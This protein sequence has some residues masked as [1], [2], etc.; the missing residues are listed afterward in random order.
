VF[1]TV[2]EWRQADDAELAASRV[3]KGAVTMNGSP[4]TFRGTGSSTA[5][6]LVAP[7]DSAS[8]DLFVMVL[9][10]ITGAGT[11]QFQVG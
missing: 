3:I 5:T 2:G 4:L 10:P 11:L 6:S 1:S 8:R 9:A 7:S